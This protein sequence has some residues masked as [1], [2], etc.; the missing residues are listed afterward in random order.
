V[1]P[2]R[3]DDKRVVAVVDLSADPDAKVLRNALNN[4]LYNHWALRPLDSRLDEALLGD[5]VDE[6]DEPLRRARADRSE[7][8]DRL[9]RFD[10]QP[11]ALA[12]R[13]G[14]AQLGAA[15]PE[16][17]VG[18]SADLAALAGMAEL[19]QHHDKDA[20]GYFAFAHRLNPSYAVDPVRYLPEIV[21]AF[22]RA[23]AAH[24]PSVKLAVTGPGHVWIDGVDRGAAGTFEVTAGWHLVQV[25]GADLVTAGQ[26]DEIEADRSLELDA[27]VATDAKRVQ[28]ARRALAELPDDAV[29]RAGAMKQLAELLNVHD[30]VLIWKRK[31]DSKLLVQ[32]WRDREP[33]FSALRE[34]GREPAKELLAPLS[35]PEPPYVAPPPPP[36]PPLPP[37]EDE[38]PWYRRRWVQASVAGGV[39]VAVVG[40][41]LYARRQQTVMSNPISGG[42]P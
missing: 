24:A 13:D 36:L 38:P 6:D 21:D 17:A 15:S 20:A 37:V 11:A 35:P 1:A 18:P 4:T 34:R 42:F 41:I 8:E 19:E 33:G 25:V 12:A 7:A 5:F 31:D 10:F 40:A 28:R 23:A 26:L 30:A 32:T 9:A 2:A 27:Q 39:A 29:A 14:L 22:Q 3:A 16:A